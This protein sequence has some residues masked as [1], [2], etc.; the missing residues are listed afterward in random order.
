MNEVLIGSLIDKVDAQERKIEGQENQ[1]NQLREKVNITPNNPE[2]VGQFKTTLEGLRTDIKKLSF[3][4]KELRQLHTDIIT[5]TELLRQPVKKEIIYDYHSRKAIWIAGALFL[6]L[7]L[8]SAGWIM[9]ADKLNKYKA[10][11]T[12]YRYLKLQDNDTLNTWLNLIDSLFLMDGNIRN[13]V[14]AQEN[15]NRRNLEIM[16]KALKMEKEAKELKQKVSESVK[17]K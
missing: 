16:Q 14:I 10:N 9:T 1:I 11:D 17:R 6:I 12:K 5:N 15:Q 4:E 2:A 3:P 13:T 8:M 7:C